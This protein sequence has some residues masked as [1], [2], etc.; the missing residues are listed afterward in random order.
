MCK[1]THLAVAAVF[2]GLA[3]Q[4]Q[5][6]YFPGSTD[7]ED[8]PLANT[9]V[10]PSASIGEATITAD[11]TVE[12][13]G[14][15]TYRPSGFSTTDCENVLSVDNDIASPIVCNIN[16]G[17]TM[18]ASTIYADVLIK[19]TPLA[20]GAPVPEVGPNDKIF[21]YTRVNATG[22]DT[23]LCVLAK[24]DASSLTNEYVFTST[25]IGKDSWHRV[26]IEAVSDGTYKVYCDAFGQNALGT[27]YPIN[28]GSSMSSVAFAGTGSVDD[29]ILSTWEPEKPVYTLTW[30][31]G[32]DSVSYTLNGVADDPLTAADGEYAFQA[33]PN[34]TI[35]LTGVYGNRTNSV[36]GTSL[37]VSLNPAAIDMYFPQTATAGQ[38]GTAANPFE[39]AD[40]GDLLA[41]QAAV[42]ATN[43]ADI[44]FVQV[45]DIDFAGEAAFAGI[46]TYSD[47]PTA[48][49]PFAGTYNG[50][51]HKISNVTFTDRDYAGIF[52]QIN[53]GTIQNLTV[54]NLTFVGTGSKYSASI[55]G[56]AGNGATLQN[57]VAAGSFGS[58]EKPGNH[59]MAG[60]AIRLSGGRAGTLVKDCTNNAAIYG[61][62]T[63][64]AG[65]CAITQVKVSGG[66]V[67]FDGCVNN[68]NLTMPSG[69]TAGSDGLAGIVG[70][71]SDNTVLKDCQNADSCTITSTF[72]NARIGQ[73]VGYAYNSSLTDQGG[74]KAFYVRKMIG[75]YGTSAVTNFQYA[76]VS[77]GIATTVTA[78][79]QNR[80]Y[81]LEANIP[82]SETSLITLTRADDY[83][84]FDTYL[85]YTFEGTVAAADTLAI[86]VSTNNYVITYTARRIAPPS[87]NDPEGNPIENQD[88]NEWLADKGVT[89]DDIDDLGDDA[90]ATDKLYECYLLNCDL[91]E[92]GAGGSLSIT[93][94]TVSTN[95]AVTVQLI[96]KAPL[97]VGAINGKLHFYGANNLASG[98]IRA[99]IPDEN[100]EF[101]G[102]PYFHTGEP[103][104]CVTQAVPVVL[105]NITYKFFKAVIEPVRDEPE[106]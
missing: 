53:G 76:T 21:V 35:V 1:L 14:R 62:Y 48:G 95:V 24:P 18:P 105:S 88:V 81:R 30:R 87:F 20:N 41:L 7:F 104:G 56:N 90:A 13:A 40:V 70:Y 23:N 50:Q 67:T 66:P 16:G 60:I 85:G 42:Q 61:T 28:G 6:G 34:A 97:G 73:L 4:V 57:L 82:A 77:G 106:E 46:G 79:S 2:A 44:C 58:S 38:D 11:A 29:L 64:M 89:Q 96:R 65:I 54:S 69:S 103:G 33:D 72:A 15:A 86:E 25:H 94:I 102:N 26:I 37:Q 8:D 93:A 98:F 27:Y 63:K 49:V 3:T 19:G 59:N 31:E 75:E 80:I 51:E 39:I 47:N 52:N 84:G 17:E 100:I 68:G 5:A 43:C 99:P 91:T 36:T 83:I 92:Q 101:R 55:V 22:T 71:V 45:A 74:N 12:S 78:L 32:F 9:A 10:W